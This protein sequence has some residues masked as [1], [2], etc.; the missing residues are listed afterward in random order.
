M[1]VQGVEISPDPVVSGQPA[2]FNIS[3][4]TGEMFLH[5][6]VF[7]LLMYFIY[8]LI[9]LSLRVYSSNSMLRITI[10]IVLST[11]VTGLINT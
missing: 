10:I 9:W 3:A 1:K 2:T 6:L 5:V 7:T 11:Q 4:S 8:L